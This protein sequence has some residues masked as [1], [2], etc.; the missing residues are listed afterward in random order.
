[1]KIHL[2][3]APTFIKRN[4]LLVAFIATGLVSSNKCEA[5]SVIGK[6]Q[7][8]FAKMFTVDKATG[9]QEPISNEKQKQFE[10]ALA[11]NGYK[12]MLVMKSDNTYTSTVTTKD[13]EPKVH[14]GNYSISGKQLDMNIPL[15][16]GQKTTITILSLTSSQMVWGLE[17][18]GKLMEVTY[19]RI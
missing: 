12:E 7:R 11:E 16:K 17:F 14:I 15:V 9:K 3:S 2:L 13:A 10:N 18:M 4:F 6:W 5:Q 19:T 8:S 1:M